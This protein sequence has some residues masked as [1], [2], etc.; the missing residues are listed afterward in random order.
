MLASDYLFG[1]LDVQTAQKQFDLFTRK[2]EKAYI[3]I[4]ALKPHFNLLDFS[5]EQKD[6]QHRVDKI[7]KAIVFCDEQITEAK[8]VLDKYDKDSP[9]HHNVALG[10]NSP[11][12]VQKQAYE[13][14]IKKKG[15]M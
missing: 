14:N 8:E 3:L 11:S 6:L 13:A 7:R 15:L 2:K 9:E 12:E 4:K 1:D 10:M 5:Q